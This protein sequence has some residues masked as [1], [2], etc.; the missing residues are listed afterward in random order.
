[1]ESNL[2]MS[3]IVGIGVDIEEINRFEDMEKANMN[4]FSEKIFTENEIEYCY[5]KKNPYPS[6]TARFCGKEAV[7]KAFYPHNIRVPLNQIEILNKPNGIPFV[8]L[9]NND[10]NVF[11]IQI[12]LSY[13]K[14][15]AVAFAIITEI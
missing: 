4:K 12:S 1:M 5:S 3:T 10:P 8:K 7:V 15:I 13:T 11:N 14:E 9:L 6:L 2:G